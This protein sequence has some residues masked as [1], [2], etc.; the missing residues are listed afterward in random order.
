MHFFADNTGGASW[1]HRKKVS[2]GSLALLHI[3]DEV[4][5]DVEVG[6][7]LS[8][9]LPSQSEIPLP[10]TIGL[11]LAGAGLSPL[12]RRKSQKMAGG[13]WCN[14]SD[15]L[16]IGGQLFFFY[17]LLRQDAHPLARFS[18]RR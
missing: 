15:L 8:S 10:A 14:L 11:F 2:D 6:E 7:I 9:P 3:W 4:L 5:T 1:V 13:R 16:K 18:S 17:Y 12:A